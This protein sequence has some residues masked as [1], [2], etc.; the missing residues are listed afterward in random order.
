MFF[1]EFKDVKN[2]AEK[3]G[4]KW[5]IDTVLINKTILKNSGILEENI[6]DSNICSVC[7]KEKIHSFRAEGPDYG[8]ATAIITLK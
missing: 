5:K 2:F 7:S 3:D 6:E 4:E 1:D 8:L